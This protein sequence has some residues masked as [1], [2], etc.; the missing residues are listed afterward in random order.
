MSGVSQLVG[1]NEKMPYAH[2]LMGCACPALLQVLVVGPRHG[3]WG[4]ERYGMTPCKVCG[5][6]LP[7]TSSREA[8]AQRYAAPVHRAWAN[9]NA[10]GSFSVVKWRHSI[11]VFSA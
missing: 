2:D 1:H 3:T 4:I 11:C 6:R 8:T 9:F 7:S 10:S 5:L